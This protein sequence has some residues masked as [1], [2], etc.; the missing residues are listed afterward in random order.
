MSFSGF[1]P[2]AFAFFHQL[3]ANNTRAWWLENKATYDRCIRGPMEALIA[4]VDPRFQ[5]LRV[6][7]PNRDVRFASDKSPYK[8]HCGAYGE[9]EGGAGYYVHVSAEGL[10]VA[11]GYYQMARDQLARYRE[12]VDD[13]LTGAE[14]ERIVAAVPRAKAVVRPSDS[15]K[16]AP[17]GFAKDH[18]RIDLLRGK[19]LIT[20]RDAPTA[21]WMSTKKAR[22]KVEEVWRAADLVNSWLDAHVG[23]SMEPPDERDLRQPRAAG[24]MR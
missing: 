4:E 9:S 19:G 17:R 6:F 5:P 15:L 21:A 22:A 1:P 7:R 2:E 10:L 24:V 11:S 18:P 3:E 8:T 12:A 13:E 14:L 20:S 16:T 23:P